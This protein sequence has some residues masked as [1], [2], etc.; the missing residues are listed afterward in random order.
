LAGVANAVE[1]I[2]QREDIERISTAVASTWTREQKAARNAKNKA[3]RNAKNKAARAAR[4][5][6]H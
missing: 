3:A 4:R 1:L 6:N 5:N 2:G